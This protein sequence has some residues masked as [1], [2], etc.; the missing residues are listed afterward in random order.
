M[1]KDLDIIAEL[2]Q[3]VAKYRARQFEE[4]AVI[5]ERVLA[6]LPMQ[7]DAVNI[8]ALI[9]RETKKWGRA[10]R[11]A[12][13]GIAANP[14]SATLQNTLGLVLLDQRRLDEAQKAFQSATELKPN[15]LEFKANLSRVL[16]ELGQLDSA[17]DVLTSVIE[18][19]Y[20]VQAFILRAAVFAEHGDLTAAKR[21]IDAAQT[22][23]ANPSDLAMAKALCAFVEGDLDAAYEFFDLATENTDNIA[24]A[25][26]NRGM[27]R[28]LQGRFKEGWA[29]Y[30]MRHK[31]R[32]ARTVKCSFPYSEWQGEDLADKVLLMWGEQ[33][34]GESILSSSLLSQVAEEA[35]HVILECDP[36]LTTLFQQSFPG[37]EVLPQ[38]TPPDPAI[39]KAQVDYQ[40]SMLDLI[41]HRAGSLSEIGQED[42]HLKAD[43]AQTDQLRSKYKGVSSQGPLIG[44]S[45]GSPK[46]ANARIKTLDLSLWHPLLSV[47]GVTFVNLQYGED[48]TAM[49]E[50]VAQSGAT[51]ITDSDVD[52]NGSLDIA[53][54]QIAAMDLVIEVSSTPAHLAGALG[55]ETWAI[56][57]PIG[58]AGMW[59]WF[60]DREDSPWYPHVR[61]FRRQYG[62]GRDAELLNSIATE[63]QILAKSQSNR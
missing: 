13:Q 35:K 37:V 1:S 43:Q 54:S 19:E 10:E 49:D 52:L 50:F 3:A 14:N 56:I 20:L 47:S 26:V 15:L 12:Q 2:T 5:S 41:V 23:N 57:P 63:L 27:V 22:R 60:T 38:K 51:L 24:D 9:A 44:L 30:N 21:D 39:G 34:L 8:L 16:H 62:A 53:A 6:V 4:S 61:L 28:L 59:Y 48:R 18:K 7:P 33:G 45:W 46:A 40:A 32:W 58:P 29:D 17:L 31:R 25:Q 42:G 55:K 11:L 36:R